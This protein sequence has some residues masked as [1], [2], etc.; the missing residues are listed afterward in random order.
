MKKSIL[1]KTIT[2]ILVVVML[3]PTLPF[4]GIVKA[5]EVEPMI[6]AGGGYVIA[7]GNDSS[8]WGWGSNHLGQLGNGTSTVQEV[9]GRI[10]ASTDWKFVSAGKSNTMAI[11][12]DG[13]L[14][15]WGVNSFG[16][17]GDGTTNG[18]RTTP[19][20]IGTDKNWR[21]VSTSE[22]H[23]AAIKTDGTLWAWGYNHYGQLGDGT[24]TERNTPVQIGTDKNWGMVSAGEFHIAA[25]KTDGSLWAWG[26]NG[27]GQLGNGTT[28]DR[29]TPVQIGTNKNWKTVSAG[30][31]NTLA[32]S[33]DGT[34]WAWGRNHSGQLG[35]GTIT[36][37]HSPVQIGTDK[38]WNTVFAGNSYYTIA[39]KID[40]GVWA[41]G[42]SGSILGIGATGDQRTP[43]RVFDENGTGNF[44]LFT[45]PLISISLN[46]TTTNITKG[47][48]DTLIVSY[49][50]SNVSEPK[51]AVTWTTSNSSVVTVSNGVVT[52]VNPGT[53][54][55]TAKVGSFTQTC[56]VTVTIPLQSISLNK[57]STTIFKGRTEALTVIYNPSN[58]T[59][60]KTVAWTTSDSAVATV[61]NGVV[62][63]VNPGTTTITAKVGS[64]T[65]TCTVTVTAPLQSISFDKSESTIVLGLINIDILQLIY[66]PEN[67]TDNMA[68]TITS[69]NPN[70]VEAEHTILG[71]FLT[72]K[73]TGTAVITAKVG[74]HEAKCTVT[75]INPILGVVINKATTSILKGD[76][77][78]LTVSIFPEDA[79]E[80]K[81]ITW[82]TSNPNIATVSNGVVTAVSSGVAI[83]TAKVGTFEAI[84]LL[85]VMSPLKSISLNKQSMQLGK[86]GSE[87]LTV[88]FEPL[89]TTDDKAVIW[90]SS[91]INVAEVDSDGNV[92]AKNEGSA[93]ITAKV[94]SHEAKCTVTVNNNP[95]TVTSIT[96]SPST[97]AVQKGQDWQ[98]RATVAGTNN[99]AQTVTWSVSG[100][101]SSNT[102]ISDSGL[103]SVGADETASALTVIA[104]STVDTSKQGISSV[105]VEDGSVI[106]RLKGD[107]NNAD[108]ITIADAIMIFRHLADKALITDETDAWAADIDGSG[109]ITIQDAIYIFRFLADKMTL[110]ELQEIHLKEPEEPPVYTLKLIDYAELLNDSFKEMDTDEFTTRCTA[111]ESSLIFIYN[112]N[113]DI[114]ELSSEEMAEIDE[115]CVSLLV[116]VQL[117][118][119]ECESIIIECK[120]I[121]GATIFQKEYSNVM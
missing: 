70:V 93:E 87:K 57:T 109:G 86:G 29:N 32:I 38:N 90:L 43:T 62:T 39:S 96:I 45:A 115:L 14:W 103:L 53:A 121:N 20:Q 65:R 83:I 6:A 1:F 72:A 116:L 22:Y 119:P 81:T 61:S 47:N 4:A 110:N 97:M 30:S 89:D 63:A 104:T 52:A 105:A 21:M 76:T 73:K 2:L 71:T 35:D 78:K 40:S 42:Q 3:L 13:S 101:S 58:T 100:N 84:C 54:T 49:N 55:I 26:N 120:N 9:P 74:T 10:G 69:S 37:R 77:E 28:T 16:S 50:P 11:K 106:V 23:T 94:G 114:D 27:Y 17:F 46:K 111:R 41:W 34:L 112:F 24:T 25:I 113:F 79:E 44:Y 80:D 60:S 19:V 5:A 31:Q 33:T 12:T 117:D 98:F 56:T 91:N 15:T 8:L 68:A 85:A 51:K 102:K 7:I 18:W 118:I 88:N 108:G 99:P 75:V 36:T 59:D 64:F 48:T 95:V 67:T 82:T 107:V 66:N 92:S